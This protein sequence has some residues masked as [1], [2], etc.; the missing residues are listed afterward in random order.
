LG[1]NEQTELTIPSTVSWDVGWHDHQTSA[2]PDQ[3]FS[4]YIAA[5][6]RVGENLRR[7][8]AHGSGEDAAKRWLSCFLV[9]TMPTL[10]ISEVARELTAL[11]RF[12]TKQELLEYERSHDEVPA[13]IS[14]TIKPQEKSAPISF[15]E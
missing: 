11:H 2:D 3:A 4:V 6:I 7:V 1:P 8:V 13:R 9:T 12:Y 14:A 15:D 10:G 5:A